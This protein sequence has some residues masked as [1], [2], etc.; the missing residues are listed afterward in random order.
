MSVQ[1]EWIAVD[2]GTTSLRAWAMRGG[3]ACD[4]A[5]APMGMGTLAPQEFEPALLQAV[6]PWLG[7]GETPVVICGMAGARTGWAEAPYRSAPCAAAPEGALRVA[8][9]D[10]RLAV[11][12]LPGVKQA[13][14]GDVMRGEETQIA[15]FVAQNPDWDGTIVL[16]GS[17]A[18]WVQLSAREI[19]SFRTA[20][21]GEAFAALS[22]HT[23]LRHTL[24]GPDAGD[25]GEIDGAEIDE[26]AFDGGVDDG[27]ARPQ[28]LMTALFGLRAD[29]LLTGLAPDAARARLSGL[30]IG[31]EMAGLKPYWLGAQIAVIGAP[32]IS[33]L[34]ARA[35]E[36]QGAAV[37]RAD[38]T[39]ATLAGLAAARA[40]LAGAGAGAQGETP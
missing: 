28:H 13:R 40:A 34:Y 9:T 16:P 30:L 24:G 18:K 1:A 37:Q 35:L 26:A 27:L 15:G 14:P 33:G 31:A 20:L 19:V 32:G 38:A 2:W 29:A 36:R 39:D 3:R 21:T 10:P 6:A 8:G 7:P 23:V 22:Q 12:I 17:H 4:E 25:P 5:R 11:H